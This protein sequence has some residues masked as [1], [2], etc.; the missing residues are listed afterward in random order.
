VL[1][2][3]VSAL[4]LAATVL[5]Q[6]PAETPPDVLAK[7]REK[8]RELLDRAAGMAAPAKPAIYVIALMEIGDAYQKLD[9]AKAISYLR[10]AFAATATVAEEEGYS[11]RTRFQGEVVKR[12]ALISAGD[13]ADML[14]GM[15]QPGKDAGGTSAARRV[16]DALLASSKPEFDRAIEVVNLVRD[17]SDYPYDAAERIFL[18]LPKNDSRRVLVFGNALA[19][20][21]KRPAGTAF[22]HMLARLW[23]A[24]PRE[25]AQTAVAAV[26]QEIQNRADDP[27]TAEAGF[28]INEEGTKRANSRKAKELV[29]LF[30]VV[31]ELDAKLARDLLVKYPELEDAPKAPPEPPEE[32]APAAASGEDDEMYAMPLIPFRGTLNINE[33]QAEMEKYQK[34]MAKGDE[35]TKLL[36]DKPDQAMA[37]AAELPARLRASLLATW[38]DRASRE[39]LELGERLLSQCTALLADLPDATDRALPWVTIASAAHR[40]KNEKLAMEA[41]Q[42]AFDDLV[43]IYAQDNDTDMPNVALT[44]NWPSIQGCRVITWVAT[45]TFGL[46]AESL[47]GGIHNPD[48][49]LLAHVEMARALL[50]LRRREFSV[51]WLHTSK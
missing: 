2:R 42:H 36:K 20:Y 32:S 46:G 9:R 5:A 43:A 6:S 12:L 23:R 13:A 45:K 30:G 35:A 16:V 47:L 24:I 39:K 21:R 26:V 11:Y 1:I 48:L 28:S 8:A 14:R 51:Q 10:D 25:N 33:M 17:S 29:E 27:G 7:E 18:K 19:A 4:W 50:D 22:P 31:R 38:A 37:M 49:A 34:A 15:A 44:E 3:L 40:L 41:L